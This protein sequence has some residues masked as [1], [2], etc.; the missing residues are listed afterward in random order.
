MEE[1]WR[2]EL[3][4]AAVLVAATEGDFPPFSLALDGSSSESGA[5]GAPQVPAAGTDSG[6]QA[7]ARLVGIEMAVMAEV[8][9][10]LR[11]GYRPIVVSWRDILS[12]LQ[13]GS[14][15]T[16]SN[17]QEP[18]FFWLLLPF[19][20]SCAQAGDRCLCFLLIAFVAC[21]FFATV[22]F[23]FRQ[24]LAAMSAAF[25]GFLCMAAFILV[26]SVL[27]SL[28]LLPDPLLE[29][30]ATTPDE[31][32]TPQV[33]DQRAGAAGD[34]VSFDMSS[35]SMDVTP[36]R[37]VS[38]PTAPRAFSVS[39]PVAPPASSSLPFP[40]LTVPPCLH[41]FPSSLLLPP[42]L[43]TPRLP[44][45]LCPCLSRASEHVPLHT[46]VL[47]QCRRRRRASPLPHGNPV[48]TPEFRRA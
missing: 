29:A 24:L 8:C 10:R 1:E 14:P 15:A 47:Q 38:S 35:A 13:T 2:R 44:A 31:T 33:G 6:A 45:S 39:R 17:H 5:L 37:E 46:A 42:R 28:D 16:P 19:C 48:P 11:V 27:R 4:D 43:Q 41:V 3:A 25:L 32:S 20:D 12:G 7:G 30:G 40:C 22:L 9:M 23:F 21:F 26:F 34:A 18:S 36:E